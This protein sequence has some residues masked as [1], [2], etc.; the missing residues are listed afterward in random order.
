MATP[1]DAY[2]AGESVRLLPMLLGNVGG[3]LGE[4]SALLI[5][6]GAAYLIWKRTA[7]WQIMA[8]CALGAVATSGIL[9]A[10][11]PSRVGGPLFQLLA[12]GFTFG[13]VFMATDP[14]SAARTGPGKWIYGVSIGALT[15]TL[16]GYSNFSCGLMFAI[17][18]LNM[19]SPLIDAGVRESQS[20]GKAGRD[21]A[22]QES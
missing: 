18:I 7:S 11:A 19:F 10:V 20:S 5:L 9:H 1:L 21:T 2:K 17:L 16:R 22:P 4:T 6:L 3:S 8:A 12:G 13:S 15:V 14:I